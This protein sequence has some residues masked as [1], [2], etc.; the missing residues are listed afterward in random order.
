MFNVTTAKTAIDS[1]SGQ[2]K[3]LPVV[4]FSGSAEELLE[5]ANRLGVEI[6]YS[7]A[8]GADGKT[9]TDET[10]NIKANLSWL[11]KVIDGTASPN[12][13]R[14]VL[15]IDEEGAKNGFV[16]SVLD[17]ALEYNG[18]RVADFLDID[19][20]DL[21]AS[22][23]ELSYTDAVDAVAHMNNLLEGKNTDEAVEFLSLATGQELTIPESAPS[24]D[25][26]TEE[27][28]DADAPEVEAADDAAAEEQATTE[29][30]VET[31]QAQAIEAEVEESEV[32]ES[33]SLPVS[34]NLVQDFLPVIPEDATDEEILLHAIRGVQLSTNA[35]SMYLQRKV[36]RS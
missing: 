1:P 25:E 36:S 6:M 29:E 27:S 28:A 19:E 9:I 24:T 15:S 4:Q 21:S 33:I 32:E 20:K 5:T 10:A 12:I 3:D 22:L 2:I 31:A 34:A 7:Q 11:S 17:V 18:T 14:A 23:A 16:V 35:L 26:P 30:E 13:T 8:K